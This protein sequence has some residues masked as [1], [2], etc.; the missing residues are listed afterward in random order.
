MN[1]QV[2]VE[3]EDEDEDDLGTALGTPQLVMCLLK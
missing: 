2:I 1:T 3:D